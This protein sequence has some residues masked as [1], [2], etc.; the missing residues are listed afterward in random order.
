MKEFLERIS[1]TVALGLGLSLAFLYYVSPFYDDGKA[2]QT[3]IDSA[4]VEMAVKTKEKE[5]IE[6]DIAE[7]KRIKERV[8]LLSE[9]F[10][11]AVQYL[12]TEWKE[13]ALLT[14]ISK[15][16]QIAGVTVVKINSQKERVAIG[17]YEEMKID[18]EIKGSFTSMMLFIS[19]MTKIKRIVE[20]SEVNMKSDDPEAELPSLTSVGKF[21]T[22]RYISPQERATRDENKQ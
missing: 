16:A 20:V 12:P 5:K 6:S 19:N 3:Q 9:K 4:K 15:Q 2:L 11:Q 10:K 1:T 18:F 17:V 21:T 22:Y 13:D 14:D 8:N 7:A